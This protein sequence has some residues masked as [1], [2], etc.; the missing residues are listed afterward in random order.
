M[1]YTYFAKFRVDG[2]LTEENIKASS[3]SNARKLIELKYQGCK[4]Q[5]IIVRRMD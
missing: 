3:E 5:F 2:I 1:L 4:I